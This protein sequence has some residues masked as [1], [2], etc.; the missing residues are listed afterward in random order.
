MRARRVEE[1][2]FVGWA[3]SLCELIDLAC[4]PPLFAAAA[5]DIPLDADQAALLGTASRRVI[6]NCCRQWARAR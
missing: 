6:L 5:L 2:P 1:T 3:V 4:H